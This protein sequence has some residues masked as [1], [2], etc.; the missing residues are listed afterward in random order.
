MNYI[1]EIVGAAGAGKTT[2]SASLSQRSEK[3]LRIDSFR[4]PQYLPYFAAQAARL[5][6][7]ALAALGTANRQ[8][9]WKELNWMVRLAASHQ[10]LTRRLLGQEGTGDQVILLDQGPVYMLTRLLEYGTQ[11]Q[12]S[13]RFD[14][15][16]EAMLQKWANT[17]DMI[18]WVDAPDDILLQR[19]HTRNK[20]HFVKA[21]SD[22]AAISLL[23]Q[24]RLLYGQLIAKLTATGKAKLYQYDTSRF[25]LE[26][27]GHAILTEFN[28][29]T[30]IAAQI[31]PS[32]ELASQ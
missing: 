29:A 17:L 7:P 24:H 11:N 19:V 3:I 12:R 28:L 18:I 16:W 31:M 25:S 1:A 15:W 13:Q 26:Q 9:K 14:R 22:Q 6:L 5:S 4:Q 2:L 8:N 23:A 10:I 21:M 27:I 20:W 32:K 30:G